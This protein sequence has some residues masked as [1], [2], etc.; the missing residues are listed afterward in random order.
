MEQWK[1]GNDG[2]NRIYI[3]THYSNIPTLQFWG[4][5]KFKNMD[6]FNHVQSIRRF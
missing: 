4:E 2:L 5:V 1:N 3:L 6:K